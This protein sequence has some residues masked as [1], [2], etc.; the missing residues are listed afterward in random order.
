MDDGHFTLDKLLNRT[1]QDLQKIDTDK[2]ELSRLLKENEALKK[3]ML[4]VMD[5]ERHKQEVER[6][7]HQNKIAEEKFAYLKDMERRLKAMV[8]EWRKAEDKDKVVKMIAA[9]LFN[10]KEK[11]IK[12]G[13]EKKVNEKFI[14]VNGEIK[15]GDKVKMKQNWQVGV[16]KEIR[17]KKAIVQLGVIPIT[18]EMND[19]VLVKDKDTVGK[20]A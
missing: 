7:K 18:V 5:K 4:H 13:Q 16:L 8:I 11:M 12:E 14:E 19:L 10:Q 15:V 17:G 20:S 2:K 1:E 3:E 9:L 6:L